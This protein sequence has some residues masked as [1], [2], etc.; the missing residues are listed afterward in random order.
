L[1][2][3]PPAGHWEHRPHNAHGRSGRWIHLVGG[4]V[5]APYNA[6]VSTVMQRTL[7]P[8]RLAEAGAY[9][10]SLKSA[11]VPVGIFLGG[12]ATAVMGSSATLIAA[13][14]ILCVAGLAIAAGVR[15]DNPKPSH[16]PQ[17]SPSLV[18]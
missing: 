2:D 15:A 4:F 17:P 13:G 16:S 10:D 8:Q 9:L 3:G 18:D 6:I 1:A 5:Y 11:T 7:P 14:A 12:L